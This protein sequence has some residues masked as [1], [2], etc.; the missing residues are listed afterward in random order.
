MVFIAPEILFILFMLPKVD[1][2]GISGTHSNS[3]YVAPFN[4]FKTILIKILLIFTIALLIRT[5][6]NWDK[7]YQNICVFFNS[8]MKTVEENADFLLNYLLALF[9]DICP[10]WSYLP[11][12]IITVKQN[13]ASPTV[14]HR[15]YLSLYFYSHLLFFNDVFD[16]LKYSDRDFSGSFVFDA[17]DVLIKEWGASQADKVHHLLLAS[18]FWKDS[19]ARIFLFKLWVSLIFVE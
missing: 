6:D 3:R 8:W 16:I 1:F 17:W 11:I 18:L 2:C 9:G 12:I 13:N 15:A 5:P 10:N 14:H 19:F 4:I 7:A